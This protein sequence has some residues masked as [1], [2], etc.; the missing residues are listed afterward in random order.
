MGQLVIVNTY[1]VIDTMDAITPLILGLTSPADLIPTPQAA[2]PLPATS[3]PAT[4]S[5]NIAAAGTPTSKPAG[6]IRSRTKSNA[7]VDACHQA[8]ACGGGQAAAGNTADADCG[9]AA[10]IQHAIDHRGL[11]AGEAGSC[12]D[13]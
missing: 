13:L 1:H 8:T 11:V 10:R 7:Q 3:V 6:K 5:N 4:E 2:Q 9:Q 12:K